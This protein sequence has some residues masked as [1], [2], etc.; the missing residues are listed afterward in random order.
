MTLLFLLTPWTLKCG[1]FQQTT[2]AFAL[3]V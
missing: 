2:C 1:A 3:V